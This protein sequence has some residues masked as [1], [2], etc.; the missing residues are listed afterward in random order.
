MGDRRQ[1]DR[2][3][4]RIT[5]RAIINLAH[6]YGALVKAIQQARVDAHLAEVPSE[7][8]PVR[9]AATNRAMMD[10]DHPVPPDVGRRLTGNVH[11]GG[12]VVG[13]PPCKPATERTVAICD[14]FRCAREF[15][16]YVAAV[17]ASMSVHA[18]LSIP[19]WGSGNDGAMNAMRFARACPTRGTTR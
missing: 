2:R 3:D 11:V 5:L 8:L 4:C 14:P 18:I 15:H 6:L 13:N 17:A 9:A 10:T 1:P 16:L 7:R 19:V 12:R